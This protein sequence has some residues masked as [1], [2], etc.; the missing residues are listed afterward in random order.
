MYDPGS[1]KDMPFV[2]EP[3][4]DWTGFYIGGGAGGGLANFSGGASGVF[5]ADTTTPG[6]TDTFAFPYD[7][8]EGFFFGTAQIGYDQRLP[9]SFIVGVFADYD[10]NSDIE[11]SFSDTALLAV[12]GAPGDAMTVA[13]TAEVDDSWTIG[14]RLGYLLNPG[15]M[16]YALAGWTHTDLTISGTFSTNVGGGA[17]VPFSAEE[18]VDAL[19]IGAGVETLLRPGFSLKFEYRYTD[20][21]G[22]SVA[23]DLAGAAGAGSDGALTAD[24]DMDV[25]TVRA[26]LTWRPQF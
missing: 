11:T 20:L 14:A 16:V 15:T 1:L 26:V 19:T 21:G 7:N 4:D 3:A 6:T 18:D 25:H 22:L 24:S 13:G 5:D 8:D 12:S 23:A 10:F 2:A 9:A 17:P